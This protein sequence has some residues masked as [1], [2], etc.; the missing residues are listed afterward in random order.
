MRYEFELSK[1]PAFTEAGTF[2]SDA[3]LKTPAVSVPVAL[4]W[5]TGSPYA[6]YA[7]VRAITREGVSRWSALV[8]LQ[9]PLGQR[10]A[11]G[12]DLSGHVPLDAWSAARRAT[13]SG[14]RR[15]GRSSA[16]R[17]NAVDHREF[18]S[19]H[20]QAQYSGSVSWRV[21]AVRSL[22]GKIPT[23]LPTVSYGPWSPTYTTTNPAI[24]DG[25]VTPS[26]AA[27]R[28]D[29]QQRH[30]GGAPRADARLRLRRHAGR[31]RH[32]PPTST[33]S[34]SSA[35]RTASTSSIAAR[36]SARPHTSPRTTGSLRLPTTTAEVTT[37]S[38]TYL[39]DLNPGQ[40]GAPQ[41]MF[42]S[43][44][45]KSTETD[46]APAKQAATPAAPG[47]T[48]ADALRRRA[49][50]GRPRRTRRRRT[51]R[52]CPRR[53]SRPARPSISGTAAGRTAAS[54]GPPCRSASSRPT[55][56]G[57][58]S[59]S[60][61]LPVRATFRLAD[62]TGFGATQLVRIGAGVDAGDADHRLREHGDERDPDHDRLDLR[63]RR[64]R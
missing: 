30:G 34:T 16:M 28:H 62:L 17:T 63:T 50:G 27:R 48:D 19:F 64:R 39:K 42:D 55:P 36:S 32:A 22:Y 2:W 13:R 54:T 46:P 21:R 43:A 10:A 23:G 33:A 3:K 4:P 24:V 57:R 12:R 31:H 38:T 53:R 52:R 8:R 47:S 61:P 49:A 41:F 40:T 58:R 11:A 14:S 15:C 20:Q 60:R 29:G 51:T 56:S 18:Y 7:R 44:T 26:V 5:M 9:R 37:A 35:T 25:A 1:N 59:A 45:V 6:V